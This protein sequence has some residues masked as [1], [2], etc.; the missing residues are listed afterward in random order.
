M[1]WEL[2][3]PVSPTL[4]FLYF[5]TTVVDSVNFYSFARVARLD[6]FSIG[7]SSLPSGGNLTDTQ[8]TDPAHFL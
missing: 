3:A 6:S 2:L 4:L 7:I 8:K 1:Q 5:C